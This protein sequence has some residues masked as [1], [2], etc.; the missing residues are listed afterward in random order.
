MQADAFIR[1]QSSMLSPHLN[2]RQRRLAAATQARILGYRGVSL[3]ARASG[4]SR[5]AIHR[6]LKELDAEELAPDRI[7]RS[8]GGRKKIDEKSPNVLAELRALV[9]PETRGDPMSPLRW[10]CK[11]TRELALAL[12]GRGHEVT[13]RTVARMLKELGY[14]LQ[15]TVKTLEGR[16]HPDRDAQFRYITRKVA[17]FLRA[18]DPVIS[19]DTKQKELVGR[20]GRGGREYQPKGEPE[21]VK[22]HD[23]IDPDAGKA[24]PYGVYD[25]AHN[26][27]WVN[28]GS[29]HDTAEFAVESIRR[30]WNAMGA[31]VHPQAEALL[32]CADCGGSNGYRLRQWK[33]E[34]QKL[35]DELRLEITV[36]HLPP[37]A[38]KWNKIEHRLFSHISMNWRGRPLVT[39]EVV[40][41][42]IRAT[43]TK[44]GLRVNAQLDGRKYPT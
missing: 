8:G 1:E 42:L 17:A 34:L 36:C 20:Y 23:F 10:T 29:D 27:G 2:E 43:K 26:E 44:T 32:I 14:S 4:L 40:V 38:S 21:T 39:H 9:D 30:W 33:T 5:Q 28:V 18:G 7:R 16:Q 31:K 19:V 35:A 11:S 12:E 15:A 41:N 22:V 6:G 25:V 24:I 13:D 37:G 3:V